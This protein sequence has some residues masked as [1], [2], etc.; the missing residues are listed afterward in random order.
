LDFRVSFENH[1]F[2][3][4]SLVKNFALKLLSS[5]FLFIVASIV[6]SIN[7]INIVRPMPI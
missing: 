1:D 6:L 4:N 5:E 3:S 2:K 7:L